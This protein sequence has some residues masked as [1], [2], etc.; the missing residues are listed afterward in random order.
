VTIQPLYGVSAGDT[1][2]LSVLVDG[3]TTFKVPPG[4]LKARPYYATIAAQSAPWDGPGRR[5]L[6]EGTPLSYAEAVTEVFEP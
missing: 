6:R 5:P 2:S 1:A 3:A 4:F